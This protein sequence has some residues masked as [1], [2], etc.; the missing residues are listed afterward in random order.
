MPARLLAHACVFAESVT[1]NLQKNA[2]VSIIFICDATIY[3][4]YPRIPIPYIIIYIYMYT[5]I[6]VI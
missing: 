2:D 5:C 6:I 1:I 4:N 3:N